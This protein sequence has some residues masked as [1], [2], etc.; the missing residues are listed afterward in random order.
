[1]VACSM[2]ALMRMG[3]PCECVCACEC[4]SVCVCVSVCACL[5]VSVRAC[6]CVSARGVDVPSLFLL[7]RIPVRACTLGCIG[8]TAKILIDECADP[9]LCVALG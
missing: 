1:M 3:C 7:A 8:L 9:C 6:V 5:C 4:V 2:C